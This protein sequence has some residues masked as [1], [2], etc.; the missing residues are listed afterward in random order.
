VLHECA[1]SKPVD[2]TA[3]GRATPNV[4][5]I[6]GQATIATSIHDRRPVLRHSAGIIPG[7]AASSGS[8]RRNINHPR[9]SPSSPSGR[10]AAI[11]SRSQPVIWQ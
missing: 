7:S 1:K 4:A 9:E 6:A 2:R 8:S 5:A 11:R 3:N 10:L